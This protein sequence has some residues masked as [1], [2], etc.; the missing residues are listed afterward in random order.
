L[1]W[2]IA[3]GAISAIS[4]PL[5]SILGLQIKIRPFY[6]SA[7]AAFGAGALIAALSVELVA[8]TLFALGES[9]GGAEHGD[10][11]LNFFALITGAVLGGVIFVLL[12]QLVNAYGGFLRQTSKTIAYFTARKQKQQKELLHELSRFPLLKDLTPEF[13]NSLVSMV[14]PVAYDTGEVLAKEGDA[15]RE[16]VF[17]ILRRNLKMYIGTRFNKFLQFSFN[18]P[19]Q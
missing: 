1:S 13:V 16:I 9:T 3:L 15:G 7:L 2:A 19:N 11:Y 12:D 8:P 6:I 18:F 14:K 17:I 5:G 4:I 10:P